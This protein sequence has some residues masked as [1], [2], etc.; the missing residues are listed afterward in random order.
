MPFSNRD[1]TDALQIST[2]H[3]QHLVTTGLIEVDDAGEIGRGKVRQYSYGEAFQF[4]VAAWL[5]ALGMEYALACEANGF[6]RQVLVDEQ[7]FA[8]P[9]HTPSA[10]PRLPSYEPFHGNPHA[11]STMDP[12]TASTPTMHVWMDLSIS[13][14][15]EPRSASLRIVTPSGQTF[16]PLGPWR[17]DETTAW[18]LLSREPVEPDFWQSVA[19]ASV[20]LTDINQRL[21]RHIEHH[22]QRFPEYSAAL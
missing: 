20:C 19:V 10:W 4:G 18:V 13:A 2:P 17:R 6:V 9:E 1:L 12:T 3:V 14:P 7:L 8:D 21:D 11:P 22:R 15:G 5:R 16:G